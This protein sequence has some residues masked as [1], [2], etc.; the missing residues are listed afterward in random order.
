METLTLPQAPEFVPPSSRELPEPFARAQPAVVE[1]LPFRIRVARDEDALRKAV[2]IRHRAYARHVP[3]LA[4]GLRA[5]EHDDADQ[6]TMILLAESRLDGLPVGTIRVQS[7]RYRPLGVEHSVELPARLQGES[8]VEATRLAVAGGGAGRMVKAA[9]IKALYLHCLR[10]GIAWVVAGAR[11]GLDRQ[12]EALLMDDLF[13]GRTIQLQHTGGIPHRIM[14]LDVYGAYDRWHRAGHP[15]FHFMCGISHPD[16]D[17]GG[18]DVPAW[19][20]LPMNRQHAA[21]H[22]A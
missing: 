19:Q 17:L 12:Y 8:M 14:A 9:L 18:T 11:P 16:I 15:L 7:N 3:E 10:A 6:D 5:P 1:R 4:Q 13:P 21:F 22:P 2:Q 20:R